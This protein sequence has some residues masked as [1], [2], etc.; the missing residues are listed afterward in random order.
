[1]RTVCFVSSA[2]PN[3][4][5]CST[6]RGLAADGAGPDVLAVQDVSGDGVVQ[7]CTTNFQQWS[8]EMPAPYSVAV[9]AI[10]E[11][12]RIRVTTNIVGCDPEDV[13]IGMPVHIAF[14]QVE[15]V[16]LP[17]FAPRAGPPRALP[18]EREDLQRFRSVRPMARVDKFEDDVAVTGIGMSRLGPEADGGSGRAQRRGDR[19]GR[20]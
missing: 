7:S 13:H 11:D 18:D 20:A 2:A 19:T 16:W 6:R 5:R 17:L 8:P 9:V 14:E 12:D 3:A 15:D 10:E 1:M 4:G